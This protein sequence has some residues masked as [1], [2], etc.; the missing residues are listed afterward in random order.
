MLTMEGWTTI[1]YLHAQGVGIRAICKELGLARKTVRRA[2]RSTDTPKYTRPPRPNRQMAPFA[3]QIR[4]WYFTDHLIG[5]RILREL[6]A[7]G[8]TGSQSALYDHLR[9]LRSALPMGGNRKVTE[10]FETAPGQQAQFDWSPY[11]VTLGGETRRVLVYGMTLGYSRRIHYTASLDETQGSIFEAIE[12]ALWHFGGVPK[13]LLVDNPKAFV[14]D[15]NPAHF[16]WNPQ[17]LELCGHYRLAPRACQV[18]RPQTKGKVERPFFYLEQQFV[19][20]RTFRSLAHFLEELAAFERD[21]LDVRVHATTQQRPLDRFTEEHPHLTPLPAHRFVGSRAE[22]RKVSW[23]CF[24][25]FRA[26]RYSVPAAYAGKLVWLLVSRGEQL[27]VVDAQRQVIAEHAIHAG[28]G[29]LVVV[30]AHYA[31]VRQGTPRTYAVLAQAFLER[32]PH[33]AWFLERLT[34]VPEPSE[35]SE[36]SV[37]SQQRNPAQA[38]RAVMELVTL[39][40]GESVAHALTL[41][42]AHQTTA[43]RFLRGVLEREG[44]VA[45][46]TGPTLPQL[47]PPPTLPPT[48]PPAVPGVPPTAVHADLSRYQQVLESAR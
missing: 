7:R 31:G 4:T 16:R 33:H 30:Q 45:A 44:S 46:A 19:K 42:H 47:A 26:N 14:L 20:G 21:D 35:S 8:Y 34:A 27:V 36:S 11:V 28:H 6:R 38:L 24:V 29:Q 9:V 41:A 18:R 12:A 48:L 2:L 15:A 17:F 37:P 13:E 1:R 25:S 3:A 39:Y 10:R 32:F 5:S 40:D 23:D 43:P 22:T